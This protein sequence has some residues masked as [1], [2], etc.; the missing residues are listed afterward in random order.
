MSQRLVKL[1]DY[2]SVV[3]HRNIMKLE[4]LTPGREPQFHAGHTRP[5]RQQTPDDPELA[6]RER[7]RS[8]GLPP[9]GTCP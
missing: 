2:D 1:Y 4:L 7:S 3:E 8:T 5:F 9:Q 6:G